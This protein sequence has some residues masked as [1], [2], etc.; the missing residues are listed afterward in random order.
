MR[1]LFPLPQVVSVPAGKLEVYQTVELN[2]L[3]AWQV[4]ASKRRSPF[5]I[6]STWLV[7]LSRKSRS[8]NDVTAS[9][10]LKILLHDSMKA[11]ST[12]SWFS[13]T[14]CICSR[15]TRYV[16]RDTWYAIVWHC[17]NATFA[18]VTWMNLLRPIRYFPAKTCAAAMH[19]TMQK[20]IMS[21]ELK[22]KVIII[23]FKWQ[24]NWN[25]RSS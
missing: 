10:L 7:T 24:Q 17:V 23:K 22:P 16:I 14:P 21:W 20:C 1:R 25:R 9:S 18:Y 5:H 11:V 13:P 19:H 4:S 12:S 3:G 8:W 15:D 2:L 6:S